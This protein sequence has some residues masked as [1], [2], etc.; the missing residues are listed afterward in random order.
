MHHSK[1]L[2]IENQN[3]CC[4]VTYDPKWEHGYIAKGHR[5][6]KM[7]LGLVTIVVWVISELEPIVLITCPYM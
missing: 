1:L 7:K 6:D 3:Q 2:G 5:V 4:V